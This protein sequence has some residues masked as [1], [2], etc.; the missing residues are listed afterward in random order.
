MLHPPNSHPGRLLVINVR[1][2]LATVGHA[3]FKAPCGT[4]DV[5]H[6]MHLLS[7]SDESLHPHC[8]FSEEVSQFMPVHGD[9]FY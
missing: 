1:A 6:Y 8:R 2:R 9:I 3:F 5:Q 7:I 4:I